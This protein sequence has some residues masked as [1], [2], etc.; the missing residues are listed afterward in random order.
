MIQ[1]QL[2]FFLSTE[3]SGN[4]HYGV[5]H[6]MKPHRARLT[7]DLLTAYGTKCYMDHMVSDVRFFEIKSYVMMETNRK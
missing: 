4:Y 7:D 1:Y 5:G 6:P 3:D 2:V